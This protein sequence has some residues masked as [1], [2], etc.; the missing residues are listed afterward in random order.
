[1]LEQSY[2]HKKNN[3]YKVFYEHPKIKEY[4]I[5]IVIGIEQNKNIKVITTYIQ[6]KD[7]RV[8]K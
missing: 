2:N 5:I 7:R 8:R 3:K 4:D 6:N 1:M